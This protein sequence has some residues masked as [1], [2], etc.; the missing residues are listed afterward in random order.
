MSWLNKKSY[1]KVIQEMELW[2]DWKKEGVDTNSICKKNV[3][4]NG[5]KYEDTGC[6][7]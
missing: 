4:R 5:D 1:Q 6:Y 2:P 3:R 7:I